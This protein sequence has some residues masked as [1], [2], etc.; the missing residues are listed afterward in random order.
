MTEIKITK[1]HGCGNDFVFMDY[2]E[3]LK[4]A[5]PVSELA[6]RLCDRHFGVGAD[7]L[8]IPVPHEG[9]D[10]DGDEEGEDR[11]HHVAPGAQEAGHLLFMGSPGRAG[12]S[13]AEPVAPVQDS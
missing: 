13:A 11:D 3:H 7:G 8:I 12:G 9:D 10:A 6:K 5:M 2:E 1:M 4:T